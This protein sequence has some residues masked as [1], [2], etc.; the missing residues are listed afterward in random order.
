MLPSLHADRLGGNP[1]LAGPPPVENRAG[2]DKTGLEPWRSS[3]AD[4]FLEQA[5][6]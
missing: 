4:T 2:G 6:G 5:P 3:I 1:Y